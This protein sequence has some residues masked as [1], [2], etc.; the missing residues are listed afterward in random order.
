METSSSESAELLSTSATSAST[1]A[2]PTNTN[3]YGSSSYMNTNTGSS[4][5]ASESYMEYEENDSSTVGYDYNDD[6]DDDDD[7]D[8]YTLEEQ[9]RLSQQSFHLG[10]SKLAPSNV[11]TSM[12]WT[13]SFRDHGD[14][15]DQ[16]PTEMT[17]NVTLV[18]DENL[19]HRDAGGLY[20]AESCF[21]QTAHPPNYA[22]TVNC[23]IY[24]RILKEVG[25]AHGVPCGMYFCCHGGEG[26]DSHDDHV[27]ITL[28]WGCLA[29]I[30]GGMLILSA[31]DI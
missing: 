5:V 22:V 23:D 10:K 2:S 27:D 21:Y 16:V 29:A 11:W 30:F 13:E 9:R 1:S 8:D 25:D 18:L 17:D 28:A 31:F 24:Q 6:D 20:Y 7:D 12:R 26:A 15:Y 3:L 4:T 14:E 19:D